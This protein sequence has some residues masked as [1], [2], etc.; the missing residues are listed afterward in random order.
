MRD[1]FFKEIFKSNDINLIHNYYIFGDYGPYK[2]KTEFNIKILAPTG[3]EFTDYP[4]KMNIG[5]SATIYT[6][7][8]GDYPKF[9]GGGY[10]DEE[11]SCSNPDV[12]SYRNGS[13]GIVYLSANKTGK[14]MLTLN[15]Y[16]KNKNHAGSV[17]IGSH[18]I[19]IEVTDE[20][21]PESI[22]LTPQQL[23]CSSRQKRETLLLSRTCRD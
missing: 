3:V 12:I 20:N 6:N 17:F 13:S 5:E 21:P 15:V 22:S 7:Y 18:S 11:I 10:F 16:A 2:S 19:D 14:A 9:V 4:E 1:I 23:V 8:K